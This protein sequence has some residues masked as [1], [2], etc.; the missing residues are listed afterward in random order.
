[1]AQIW[2]LVSSGRPRAFGTR[3]YI[4]R[5]DSACD[6]GPL[7]EAQGTVTRFIHAPSKHRLAK[8]IVTGQDGVQ[9]AIGYASQVSAFIDIHHAESAQGTSG[10]AGVD[11]VLDI[12]VRS[13]DLV[14]DPSSAHGLGLAKIDFFARCYL[15]DGFPL[16][17]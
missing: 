5:R 4:A 8:S 3:S 6:T 14:D 12:F 2:S 11:S 17:L 9:K 15:E 16:K 13:T 7:V 1:M 10:V